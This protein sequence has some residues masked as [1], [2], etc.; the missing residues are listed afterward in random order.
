MKLTRGE[1]FRDARANMAGS[2]SLRTVAQLS[3]IQYGTI[4]ALEDDENDRGVSYKE[5]VKLAEFY[6]VSIDYLLGVTETQ[7]RNTTVQAICEATGLSEIAVSKFCDKTTYEELP[8]ELK[9]KAE[10]TG[11][12][13]ET[14]ENLLLGVWKSNQKLVNIQNKLFEAKGYWSFLE[15][16]DKYLE[17]EKRHKE[18][19]E[20]VSN[21]VPKNQTTEDFVKKATE[22][23]E[24][25]KEFVNLLDVDRE[26]Q[27]AKERAEY[28]CYKLNQSFQKLIEGIVSKELEQEV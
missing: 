23:E 7:S 11:F 12:P 19:K 1:R 28:K 26:E 4:Q 13:K 16:L 24:N 25:M 18:L 17:V 14:W 15:E 22:S 6:N 20:K 9:K 3:G 5:V 8:E 2:P 27:K 21:L 10:S